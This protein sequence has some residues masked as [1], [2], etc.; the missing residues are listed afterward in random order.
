MGAFTVISA[1][2][3]GQGISGDGRSSDLVI[4]SRESL[5]EAPKVR[6]AA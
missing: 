3:N 5:E 1:T 4:R 6:T 2:E